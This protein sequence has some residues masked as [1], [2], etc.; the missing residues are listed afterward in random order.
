[1]YTQMDVS[2]QGGG[3]LINMGLTCY[4]NAVIQNLRHLSKLVWVLEE[5]KYNTLFKK[6]AP[7]RRELY[8]SLTQA[9]A[10]V[11]QMLGKCKKGQSVRPGNFWKRII[12]AVEDTLYEQF[13]MKM[14]HDSHE[15]YQLVLETIHQ[16]TIQDVDMKIIRPPPTTPQEKLVHG[17]LEAWQK[18]FV[19]EYSP[20]VHMFYGLYHQRT[21]CQACNNMTHRW[22]PFNSLKVPTQAGAVSCDVLT[23]LKDDMLSE[24]MIDEYVCEAC[25]PPR[26][27]AKKSMSI[28]KLPSVLVLSLKRFGNDG[29]KISVPAAP[30]QPTVDFSPYFSEDSPERVAMNH[31]TLRGIVD[32]H[33]SSQGGHY[34]AQ[35]R[36]P[37]SSNWYRYDDEHVEGM[38][39]PEFGDS[40]YMM[41]FEK[42]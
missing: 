29:N 27:P 2:L 26:K 20:F 28:W 24:E 7:K 11:V 41:F 21:V 6:E 16:S 31:Y 30:I 42:L 8:Q 13:A 15:F 32:H 4:G 5:G 23:S 14:F 37:V 17:A 18:S 12:P 34:T 25:G 19:K 36:H 39:G 3:G 40:T 22:E 1:M 10:E 35:C 38:P 33:G 9:F